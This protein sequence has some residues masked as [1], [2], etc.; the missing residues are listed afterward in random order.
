MSSVVIPMP[1]IHETAI[2]HP[3]AVLGKNVEIGPYAVIDEEVVIGD[4]CKIG[5]HAVIHKYTTVGKNCKFFPGC[6]IGAD[7][8]D[9]KL[10]TRK[11]RRL[12]VMAV[13]FV[14]VLPSTELLVKE[15]KLLLVIIY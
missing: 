5:A 10:K 13:F 9:L 11:H 2:I 15:I 8:Q 1:K 7:P 12:S 14:N 6:S 3:N 4:N